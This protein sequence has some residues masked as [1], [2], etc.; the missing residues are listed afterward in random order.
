MW[1]KASQDVTHNLY[2]IRTK[3]GAEQAGWLVE[4]AG[5]LG[6]KTQLLY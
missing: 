6:T 2:G 5:R 3:P 1:R 4:A